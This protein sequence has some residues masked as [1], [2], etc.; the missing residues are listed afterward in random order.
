MTLP[1]PLLC[2]LV[3]LATASVCQAL[4][5]RT[6]SGAAADWYVALKAAG[7]ASEAGT[8]YAYLDRCGYLPQ[9]VH[10]FGCSCPMM[11]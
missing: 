6:A 3:A 9:L 5:C 4:S 10:L 8:A 7:H 11:G 1:R 2:C